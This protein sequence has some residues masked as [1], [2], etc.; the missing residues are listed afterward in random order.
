MVLQLLGREP[1]GQNELCDLQKRLQVALQIDEQWQAV[2][3]RNTPH[4][5]GRVEAVRHHPQ[6]PA[7]CGAEVKFPA[8][9]EGVRAR[10]SCPLEAADPRPKF[11]GH[12]APEQRPAEI[13]YNDV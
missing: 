13:V 4:A 5:N 2:Q 8:A 12:A 6:D 1:E 11:R 9:A 3:P 10:E 7:R